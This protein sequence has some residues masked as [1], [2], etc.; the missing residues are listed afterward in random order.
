METKGGLPPAYEFW[1]RVDAARNERGWT[2]VE[3]QERSGVDRSTVSRLRTSKR[4]PLP[5]TVNKLA[6]ALGI[7]RREALELAGLVVLSPAERALY[8]VVAEQQ[9]VV[10]AAVEGDAETE[11]LLRKLSPRR[12][13]LLEEFREKERQRLARIAEDVAREA[14][15]SSARFAAMVRIEADETGITEQ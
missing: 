13:A 1:K 3:L 8:D 4:A 6:E 9:Q 12:R 14:E 5:E 11:E 7:P 10:K 2:T 15:E